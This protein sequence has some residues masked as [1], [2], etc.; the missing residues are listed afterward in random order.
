MPHTMTA[1]CALALSLAV[2]L[3]AAAQVAAPDTPSHLRIMNIRTGEIRTIHDSPVLIEAPNWSRDGKDLIYNSQGHLYRIPAA[4][5]GPARIDTGTR[6][7]LNNDHGLS[8]DGTLIAISDQTQ[9]EASRVYV[10]PS[11][12]GEPR[13]VTPQ[14]PSYWHGWSPDGKTLAIVGERDG[15]FDIYAV[16]AAGGPETQLT[17]AIGLDDGPDYDRNGNIWFNS[18]RSGHMQI[19]HM[20]PDGSQQTRM[21]HDEAYGDWFPHPS[22]DG[23]WVLFLSFNGDVVGHPPGQQVRLRLMPLD[24]SAKPR[25]V[26][27]LYGGQ[28]T[29]NVNSWSPDSEEFAFVAYDDP[30]AP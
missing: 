29:L 22:P 26:T 17:T 9:D 18:V 20:K 1:L 3:P 23:K 30:A 28:G 8:P 25:V 24:G 6:H 12:G 15:E 11:A 7:R 14:G 10:L 16:P 21:T 13:Q 4:G 27:T 5:G 2:A 19:Y